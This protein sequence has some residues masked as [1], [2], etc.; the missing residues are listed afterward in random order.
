[1]NIESEEYYRLKREISWRVNYIL[2]KV[3]DPDTY[4]GLYS[5]KDALA[6]IKHEVEMIDF[7]MKSADQAINDDTEQMFAHLKGA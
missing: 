2:R 1:M 5:M 4:N 6:D 7:E 3:N